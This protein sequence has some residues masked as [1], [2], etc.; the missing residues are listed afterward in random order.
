MKTRVCLTTAALLAAIVLSPAA[1]SQA[2]GA[3]VASDP[4]LSIPPL[5][6]GKPIDYTRLAMQP[7]SWKSRGLSLE[8]TPWT[9]KKVVFL[10]TNAKFDHRLMG[11]WV[12][13]L[14]AGWQLYSD[15]T[16]RLPESFHQID[17]KATIAAVPTADVT[18][19]AG[20]G[21]IGVTGI[22]LAMFYDT[23]YPALKTHPKAMPHYVFYEM[24]RNFYTFGDRHS[25]F[26]TGFAVFMRYVCMDA[27]KCEDIEPQTRET[28][29][30]VERRFKASGLSFLDLFTN[31]TW[32]DEKAGRIKDAQ[33]NTIDPSDQPVCYASAMLR[34]RREN[35][36][37]AW[38]MRF[39]QHLAKCP[40]ANPNT[41]QG[42]LKQGMSWMI[43]ASL[44]AQKDLSPVFADAW[45]FPMTAEQRSVLAK[46]D[47]KQPG[48]TVVSITDSLSAAKR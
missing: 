36:G 16:G 33:G 46:I 24:G 34:L 35:G 5:T 48:L 37:D 10:T 28:I 12:S 41:E 42:G 1:P 22:E 15:L 27:L 11:I 18:C 32:K 23:N 4:K 7:R 38:L 39:F 9:G 47:W 17:G 2:A 13:Q 40:N 30:G 8:L 29:E 3:Q 21:Y 44:A 43:C 26:I 6:P 45:H 19:G 20:C 25:C 14:D 31:T